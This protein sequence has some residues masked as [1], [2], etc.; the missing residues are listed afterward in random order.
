MTFWTVAVLSAVY[1]KCSG[2]FKRELRGKRVL[3]T[4]FL[5]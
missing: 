2:I 1:C 3:P 5:V 4:S